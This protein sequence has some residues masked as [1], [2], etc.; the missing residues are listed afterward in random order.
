[1]TAVGASLRVLAGL[2]LCAATGLAAGQQPAPRPFEDTIA[3]RMQAC[4]TC[5]GERGA[6]IPGSAFPRIA[7]QPARYLVAQMRAFRDGVRIYAPMNFLMSRQGDAYL[8]EI[9]EYFALQ[10]PDASVIEQRRG[11]PY[12]RAAY[13]EGARLVTQGR[14]DAGLPACNACHGKALMGMAPS[15][16]ALAGLPRDFL[17]EQVG[18]WKTGADRHFRSPEPN[19]M[20]QV[21]KV[22]T[23]AD[24]IAAATWLSLQ[25]AAGSP[26]PAIPSLPLACGLP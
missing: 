1:M 8:A 21:A 12:D 3:Q 13:D 23:G 16:P 14:A 25:D 11:K 15:I 19:C 2:A 17:I 5:H 18:S 20:A 22:M 26:D 9:A 24:I 4:A 7:G 10:K 6:G